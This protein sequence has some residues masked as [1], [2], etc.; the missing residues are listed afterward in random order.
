MKDD[1]SPEELSASPSAASPAVAPKR[2]FRLSEAR[3]AWPRF[4]LVAFGILL[5]VV[6]WAVFSVLVGRYRPVE[7]DVSERFV[8]YLEGLRPA[9]KLVLLSATDRYTASK[10]FTAKLLSLLKIEASVEISAVADTSFCIDLTDTAHWRASYNPRTRHLSIKAPAPGIL[11]PAVRTETIEVRTKGANLISSN[12]FSLKKE[13]EK[14]RSEL[15]ADIA[16]RETKAA[17]DPEIRSHIASNLESVARSFC[18][19]TLNIQPESVEV[20]FFEAP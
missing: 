4:R 15:S 20:S 16:K 19:S 8:L 10:D 11:P 18:S 17:Q 6:S 3:V 2:R 7:K 5:L 14:M 13:A 12:V 1:P 9:G